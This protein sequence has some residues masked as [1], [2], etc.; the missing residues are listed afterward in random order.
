MTKEARKQR[1][2]QRS[3]GGRS[4]QRF[5]RVWTGSGRRSRPARR[6]HLGG[7]GRRA[8]ER[9][10]ERGRGR[11]P[12]A[13]GC[14]AAGV[15]GRG[16]AVMDAAAAEA[17]RERAPYSP[18]GCLRTEGRR[19]LRGRTCHWGGS[20]GGGRTPRAPASSS[21]PTAPRSLVPLPPPPR[22]ARRRHSFP[23]PQRLPRLGSAAAPRPAPA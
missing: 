7:R 18:R 2:L 22:A 14:A 13:R 21:G 15:P 11:R 6:A 10:G 19:G 16:V 8:V 4:P 3:G 12:G 17:R 1:R 5:P 20:R 23:A 9:G